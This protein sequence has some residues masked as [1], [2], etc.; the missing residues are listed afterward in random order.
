M[1]ESE[2]WEDN[3]LLPNDDIVIVIVE[4]SETEDEDSETEDENSETEDEDEDDSVEVE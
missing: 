3:S 2:P 4:D 1:L